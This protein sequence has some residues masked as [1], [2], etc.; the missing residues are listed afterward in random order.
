M[1]NNKKKE[2]GF[3]IIE[4]MI[5]LSL[6]MI[7]T[8][9]IANIYTQ[10]R[11]TFRV[12][13]AIS[14]QAE[15]GKYAISTI[16]RMIYQAGYINKSNMKSKESDIFLANFGMN[17]SEVIKGDDQ[18]INLRF[19]GDPD[20]K[21]ISCA[22]DSTGNSDYPSL[23]NLTN[24]YGYRIHLDGNTLKCSKLS[25][26]GS[27]SD[28]QAI[29]SNVVDFKVTYGIDSDGDKVADNYTN[30]GSID[31]KKVYSIKTCIV[32]KSNEIN[33]TPNTSGRKYLN[34]DFPNHGNTS[35]T[36]DDG[37]NYRTFST[38]VYLRNKVN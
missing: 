27:I 34:C 10:T 15:E 8:L 14:N 1:L 29:A 23:K 36:N 38:T 13:S 2:N 3:T 25:S 9:A 7:L 22:D 37:R 16:Q 20:G 4:L 18:N 24:I 6:A 26:S 30:T 19:M 33:L 28:S 32:T 11:Q 31:W 35:I 21:I 17:G 5:G 12:Q